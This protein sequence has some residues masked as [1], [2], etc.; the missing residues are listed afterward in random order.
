MA[1]VKPSTGANPVPYGFQAVAALSTNA[2]GNTGADIIETQGLV[3]FGMHLSSGSTDA[4]YSF[5]GAI[6]STANLRTVL[7]ST[8]N[9]LT[10]GSTVAGLMNDRVL[11]FGSSVIESL[12][13]LRYVQIQSG[14]TVAPIANATGASA[15]MFFRK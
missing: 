4:N 9:I 10:V 2:D 14:T 8:G 13:G 11:A 15:K 1:T 7:G 6:D 5:K 12:R 3:P